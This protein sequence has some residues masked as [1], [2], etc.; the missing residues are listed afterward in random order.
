MQTKTLFDLFAAARNRPSGFDY[1]RLGLS[2]AVIAV[3][4]VVALH[5]V[6]ADKAM[7][8][9]P[10]RPLVYWILPGF[11][12]LSGFLVA[13]SLERND[14]PSF[15]A[16][17]AL[18]LLPALS[19]EVLL[20]A[21]ILGSV[22]TVLPLSAYF[23]HPDFAHYLLN[24]L[25]DIHYVLPGVFE[26]NPLPRIVNAQ[27]WTVPHE[28]ECYLAISVV[29]L[30]TLHTRPLLLMSLLIAGSS[31]IAM[32]VGY[33]DLRSEFVTHAATG[34]ILVLSFLFGVCIYLLRAVIPASSVLMLISAAL[35]AVFVW[36]EPLTYLTPLPAAYLTIYM[37]VQNP[38]KL[39]VLRGADY[40]YGMYLYGF[41]IQQTLVA[42]APFTWTW[43]LHL[44]ASLAISAGCAFLS[45]H[46]VEERV[47]TV[48]GPMLKLSRGLAGW[49][50]SWLAVRPN[51][52]SKNN[53]TA[54]ESAPTRVIVVRPPSNKG[55]CAI[56][57]STRNAQ[58]AT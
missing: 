18:R 9:G 12:A 28:L 15:L 22:L 29:G 25:G 27:L 53:P 48:K 1:L 35:L 4:T 49:L 44:P 23:T 56:H 36:W 19:V 24:M 6:E 33:D 39:A 21:I 52:P 31:L 50:P 46:Y 54:A 14:L 3:H 38:R 2:V 10:L 30:L 20:S 43:W 37:G 42:V 17:R 47:L 34:P 45:W 32:R 8:S 5:G 41:P 57:E 40:S 13:G 7:F 16:L 11:F 51:A 58:T 55:L 26:H